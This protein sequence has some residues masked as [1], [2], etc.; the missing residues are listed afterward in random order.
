MV[1]QNWF[2]QQIISTRTAATADIDERFLDGLENNSKAITHYAK[3]GSSSDRVDSALNGLLAPNSVLA[4]ADTFTV[5]EDSQAGVANSGNLLGNDIDPNGDT[6]SV[7]SF[8]VN[9][10]IGPFILGQAITI[11][12]FGDF[13]L[14]ANGQYSFIPAPNYN[15]PVPVI[16]YTVRIS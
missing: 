6:F 4:V 9:G 15:G 12:G 1:D 8:S 5:N 2:S 13:T 7:T 16:T 14:S 3:V 11:T 10:Q